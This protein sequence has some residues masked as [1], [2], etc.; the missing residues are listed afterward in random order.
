[1]GRI[2]QLTPGYALSFSRLK[3]PLKQAER[4]AL[5]AELGRLEAD[6]FLPQSED[7]E[8]LLSPPAVGVA[9]ARRVRGYEMWVLYRVEHG[10]L[11]SLHELTDRTPTR[12]G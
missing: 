8:A 2:L 7:F 3:P 12:V 10:G 6:P 9:W 11:A 4:S 1:V 5:R